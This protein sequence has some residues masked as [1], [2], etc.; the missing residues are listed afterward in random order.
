MAIAS[1][2]HPMRLSTEDSIGVP[3]LRTDLEN[4][5]RPG[6]IIP[7]ELGMVAVSSSL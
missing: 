4:V 2:A 5:V 3:L 1:N 7:A 6:V